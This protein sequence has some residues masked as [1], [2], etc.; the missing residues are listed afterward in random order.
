MTAKGFSAAITAGYR[1]CGYPPIAAPRAL[2]AVG[3]RPKRK[4]NPAELLPPAVADRGSRIRLEQ[5]DARKTDDSINRP[6]R[7][8]YLEEKF[9]LASGATAVRRII[10]GSEATSGKN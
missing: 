6:D 4:K 7:S 1:S 5:S 9:V 2:Y 8:T 10:A 3:F